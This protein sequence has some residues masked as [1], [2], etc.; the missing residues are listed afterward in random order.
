MSLARIRTK[1]LPA[2]MARP[3]GR[4]CGILGPPRPR[5]SGFF[6][7]LEIELDPE[8][9]AVSEPRH[10]RS[11]SSR[12]CAIPIGGPTQHLDTNTP[13]NQK[14]VLIP[15]PPTQKM[16]SP[17]PAIPPPPPRP[18]PP[19]PPPHLH[20]SP[21]PPLAL[22]SCPPPPPYPP[23]IETPAAKQWP[24]VCLFFLCPTP[25]LANMILLPRQTKRFRSSCLHNEFFPVQN[26]LLWAPAKRVC[27]I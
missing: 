25:T 27:L 11:R 3:V 23:A 8:I 19:P 14:H 20:T 13:Q 10:I 6:G 26:N 2:G 16:R 4:P 22:P 7:N 18:L 24:P 12:L 15:H 17:P 9:A 21:P 5:I 1:H